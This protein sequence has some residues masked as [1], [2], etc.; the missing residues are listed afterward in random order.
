MP[1]AIITG[2]TGQDG[3]YLAELL[4]SKGY[5]VVG[6][7]RRSSTVTYERIEH[8][9]D[10]ISVEQG[11]LTDQGSLIALLEE[12]R[13]A[14]VY[15]LAAQSFV[16][17]SWNQP[18]LTGDVTAL[19]VTRLLEAIRYVDPK[20]R[21]YQASSSEMFGKVLEVP[22]RETTPF[23]PRSP[24]GVAKVYGHFIAVNY[25]ESFNLFTA[26]GIL[27][28]HESPRRG[29][30]FVTRKISDGAAKIKLGLAEELRLGNLDAQRDWGFAGDYV[31]AMWRMLQQDKP[32]NFVIG[33]GET[34]SV[35]EFCEIAFGRVDLDYKKYVVMDERYYRP[36]EVD[37]LISDPTKAGEVLGWEPKV[38]F[39]QLVEMMVDSDM[40]RLSAKAA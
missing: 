39:K 12:Y 3:S 22:Q 37:L 38:G 31:D 16:P 4:L 28:N 17:T 24:Y 23:Y 11:D 36:A 40:K 6:V 2:I 5:K 9:L 18:A 27:F 1:T 30:E 19:G 32:D 26:S 8:L 15:N 13:P 14:E 29:L 7:A 10:K 20:I 35:R 33:T 25:R 34:H 21:F